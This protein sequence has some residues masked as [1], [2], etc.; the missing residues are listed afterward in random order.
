MK[1][2]P[3]GT[4]VKVLRDTKL[5]AGEILRHLESIPDHLRGLGRGASWRKG[6]VRWA[7]SGKD[8]CGDRK[9]PRSNRVSRYNLRETLELTEIGG[10]GIW[11]LPM[12]A[13]FLSER[14]C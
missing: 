12:L 6:H 10:C 11:T 7:Q 3:D 8:N 13:S 4:Q 5:A 1:K 9:E 2:V 14:N